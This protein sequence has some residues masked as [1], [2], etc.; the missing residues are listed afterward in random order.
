MI[1]GQRRCTEGLS[2][3][4]AEHC[5]HCRLDCALQWPSQSRKERQMQQILSYA[6]DAGMTPATTKRPPDTGSQ[7]V[8]YLVSKSPATTP[9]YTT[10]AIRLVEVHGV[11]AGGGGGSLLVAAG[12][13]SAVL[14]G[15]GVA[16]VG[17]REGG[18]ASDSGLFESATEHNWD[19]SDVVMSPGS[20]VAPDFLE[21][22]CRAMEK[23]WE[24]R[25]RIPLTPNLHRISKRIPASSRQ[26]ATV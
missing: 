20:T 15:V 26:V 8:P 24:F 23:P 9:I 5:L 22:S 16:L 17:A 18:G 2:L 14:G 10:S 13:R 6:E 21:W 19:R 11:L 1:D 12:L 25:F 7:T 3:Q 4:L